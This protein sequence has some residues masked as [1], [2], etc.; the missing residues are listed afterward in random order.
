M[1]A[2]YRLSQNEALFSS[3]AKAPRTHAILTAPASAVSPRMTA[4]VAD[5][6]GPPSRRKGWRGFVPWVCAALFYATLAIIQTWPL[7]ASL[8][9]VLPNDLGDPVLNAWILW[10]NATAVPLTERW[11]NA[12]MFWPGSGALA[13][14]EILLG[15]YPI[16]TPIQWLGGSPITAYN[17]MFLLTFVLSA[18]AAHVLV[19][20][21]SGRH[22]AALLAGL[23]YGFNPFR[24][25]HFPQIQVMAS[26][27]MPV[28][29]LALHQ[30]LGEHRTR[31]LWIFGAAWLMQALSNGYYLLFFPVLLGLWVMWFSLCRT[32]AKSLL[33]IA[34]TFVIASL[35][36]VPV[37]WTYRQVH[38]SFGFQRD[39]GQ[40][41]LIS[42][43]L[44]SLLD[45]SPLLRFW[46]LQSFHQAEGELFPGLT[47]P[48]LVILVVMRWFWSDERVTLARRACLVLLAGSLTFV[49]VA[50]SALIIG[51][52]AIQLAGG[53]LVSVRDVARPLFIGVL[54]FAAALA[55]EPRLAGI[56]RRRSPLGFYVLATGVMYLLCFGPRPRL[57]G[58]PLLSG[59]PY[60]W[61]MALPGYDVVRA[62]MRFA[63]LAMLCLSVASALAF[64]R[65]TGRAHPYTRGL[66]AVVAA[67]GILVDSWI[68]RMPLISLPAR[69]Q[70]LE[71]LPAGTA[72]ME[73]PLGD[74]SSNLEAM[75]RGMYHG[76]PV[77]NG[78]S[79]FFPQHF[80][81]LG[82]GLE[83][84][85]PKLL[86]AVTAWGPVGVVVDSQRDDRGRWAGQ[87]SAHPAV[88]FLGE[89][90]HRKVFL[91]PASPAPPDLDRAHPLP[92]RSAFANVGNDRIRF[93]L[94][95]DPDTRWDSGPQRGIEA[96]TIDLGATR[97]V[98]GL[99][100][101][102]GRHAWDF[103]RDLVIETSQDGGE[104]STHWKGSTA[105]IALI[106]A[107]R[108][109]REVPLSFVWPG[110]PAR[111]IRLRQLGEDPV[112]YW[113][114]V[115]L[116][117]FGR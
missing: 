47:A 55:V 94:D 51:P 4:G 91:L 13:F 108:H 102:I 38:T 67:A 42:A 84:R 9:T 6:A 104:W 44:T 93:A 26:Y 74:T 114:I 12:P 30:Y 3:T 8:S 27:G 89:E 97:T 32:R 7:A 2:A 95:G 77:L 65:L 86:D 14:S 45:A 56:W 71:S 113:T 53:A 83:M 116:M 79:G 103:P 75:Y 70:I 100:M 52:W 41:N 81:V 50:L 96:V 31:W 54:L 82:R 11:W 76:R 25:A 62:P 92:I 88:V 49:A 105:K 15:M 5:H 1:N 68:G 18:L 110:V 59:A 19:V 61:L 23:I 40:I 87:L 22:D 78:Y 36:L 24:V 57:L 34:M 29:L 17:V 111:L 66:L 101:N 37:L 73:L 106:G 63:M 64:A 16:T 117:V 28:A 107:V 46:N 21:L 39:V 20:R 80:D 115:E 99:A 60:S 98:E 58:E 33:A 85:D 90:S 43:D 109:P 72:V 112:F 10:W 35:P 48:L 69:F